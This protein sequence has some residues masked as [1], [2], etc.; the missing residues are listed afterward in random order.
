MASADD[1]KAQTGFTIGGVSPVGH[2]NELNIIIDRTL[3]RFQI[4][5]AAAGHPNAVRQAVREAGGVL[6]RAVR[7]E[8]E[9]PRFCTRMRHAGAEGACS[10]TTR[11][12]AAREEARADFALERCLLLAKPSSSTRRRNHSSVRRRPPAHLPSRRELACTTRKMRESPCAC[13]ELKRGRRLD[14]VVVAA[15]LDVRRLRREG[16]V[17]VG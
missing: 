13:G 12:R 5:Y 7:G 17:G 8:E 4:V 15:N 16:G 1:V 9:P 10:F 11:R 14:L 6:R 3:E 2:I